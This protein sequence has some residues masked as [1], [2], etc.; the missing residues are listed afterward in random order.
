MDYVS[1]VIVDYTGKP[2]TV[3][4]LKRI[5]GV[6]TIISSADATSEYDVKVFLGKD[7]QVP[8]GSAP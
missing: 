6:S 5:F 1:T 3:S 2:Y 8:A 4:W 7:W